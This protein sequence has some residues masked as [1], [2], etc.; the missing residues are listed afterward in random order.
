M[1]YTYRNIYI[2]YTALPYSTHSGIYI[3]MK[4]QVCMYICMY[5]DMLFTHSNKY[6]YIFIQTDEYIYRMYIH[7]YTY[8]H[9]I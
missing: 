5:I 4:I 6:V 7:I 9:K 8:I 3:S 1:L 2:F